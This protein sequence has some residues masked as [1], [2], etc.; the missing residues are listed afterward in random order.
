MSR[1]RTRLPSTAASGTL[2]RSLQISIFR[3]CASFCWDPSKMVVVFWFPFETH[4]QSTKSKKGRGFGNGI[5]RKGNR[6]WLENPF[7][8][9]NQ[10]VVGCLVP[11]F[12]DRPVWRKKPCLQRETEV[13]A[14]TCK[15]SN[16]IFDFFELCVEFPAVPLSR[17]WGSHLFIVPAIASAGTGGRVCRFRGYCFDGQR[18]TKGISLYLGL[19]PQDEPEENEI[20]S[21][22]DL[23]KAGLLTS[24]FP[25]IRREKV[26]PSKTGNTRRFFNPPG[27][28]AGLQSGGVP[29]EGRLE[30]AAIESSAA[31]RFAIEKPSV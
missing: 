24:S 28:E 27:A 4:K 17:V 23:S 2:R 30:I 5:L 15:V 9:P 26:R 11:E 25:S 19:P 20:Y 12:G 13:G 29:Q 8:C 1:I 3:V 31:R 21:C 22:C 6:K 16:S 18:Q 10:T 14:S 7:P